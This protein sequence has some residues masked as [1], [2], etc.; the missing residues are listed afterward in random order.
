MK[1]GLNQWARISSL[2]TRKSAKQCKA[3][4]YEWLDPAIKKTGACAVCAVCA[5]C[6]VHACCGMCVRMRLCVLAVRPACRRAGCGRRGAAVHATACGSVGAT[7]TPSP[8]HCCVSACCAATAPAL[9][10]LLQSGR[11]RRTRS[12]CTWPS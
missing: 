10:P 9:P 3:R 12:C 5:G 2:L 7:L 6:D 8:H 11:A 1:Y 4:W